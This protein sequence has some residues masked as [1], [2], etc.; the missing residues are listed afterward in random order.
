[1]HAG[2]KTRTNEPVQT[3][4][5]CM[6]LNLVVKRTQLQPRLKVDSRFL[7]SLASV[8]FPSQEANTSAGP[9]IAMGPQF[10]S[11]V[12]SFLVPPC[13]NTLSKWAVVVS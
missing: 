3:P 12:P 2:V 7:A 5:T 11:F 6:R 9:D 8:T 4:C 13:V 1:M 10:K